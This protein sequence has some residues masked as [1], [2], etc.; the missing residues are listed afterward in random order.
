M[1]HGCECSRSGLF[2]FHFSWA[3]TMHSLGA[4]QQEKR[5]KKRNGGTHKVRRF[6]RS[7]IL[8]ACGPGKG[9]VDTSPL[10]L[11][12]TCCELS[13]CSFFISWS[14]QDCTHV[15]HEVARFSGS[16]PS[17]NWKRNQGTGTY[18][19]R[20]HG[21]WNEFPVSDCW[22]WNAR[23]YTFL[24]FFFSLSPH[25][26]GDL[27]CSFVFAPS[28][29]RPEKRMKREKWQRL[30]PPFSFMPG[31]CKFLSLCYFMSMIRAYKRKIRWTSKSLFSASANI[32]FV[33][34][35]TSHRNIR[36]QGTY[37]WAGKDKEKWAKT[38]SIH[39]YSFLI[40][41]PAQQ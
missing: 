3:S 35:P 19:V 12:H 25:S 10:F 26:L 41:I 14:G 6:H 16:W 39:T 20:A 21:Q 30:G 9:N 37:G 34:G 15:H 33:S 22:P 23:T 5:N 31:S 8:T 7:A 27:S 28:V 1:G 4:G 32:S 24:S 17:G 18:Y 11:R 38:L 36:D 40:F 29:R 13:S 2:F